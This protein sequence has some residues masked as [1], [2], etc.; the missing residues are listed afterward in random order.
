MIVSN[1]ESPKGERESEREG[2]REKVLTIEEG[3]RR[4]GNGSLVVE[5]DT[6]KGMG[7]GTLNK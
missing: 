2:K 4:M 5:N 1:A 7:V 3:Y 6:S